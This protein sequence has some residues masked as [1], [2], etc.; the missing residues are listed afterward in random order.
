M[1]DTSHTEEELKRLD[2]IVTAEKIETNFE[3]F[4]KYGDNF[5]ADEI[6]ALAQHYRDVA[7]EPYHRQWDRSM[8]LRQ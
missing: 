3:L 2:L 6:S 1:K 5:I 8:V 7:G 4:F